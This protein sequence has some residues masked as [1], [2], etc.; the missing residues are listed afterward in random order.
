MGKD[1]GYPVRLNWTP[2][3]KNGPL[4]RCTTCKNVQFFRS[5]IVVETGVDADDTPQP[6][7]ASA[8]R[9]AQP[10][11]AIGLDEIYTDTRIGTCYWHELPVIS[12]PMTA[13][14]FESTIE[15]TF[16]GPPERRNYRQQ[17]IVL[18]SKRNASCK[19]ARLDRLM[20]TSRSSPY[21]V[22]SIRH[23]SLY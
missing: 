5:S 14:D 9:A 12:L 8:L 20:S 13:T 7:A 17:T 18:V 4:E 15:I 2:L 16:F 6:K 22:A 10:F 21:L 1:K 11:E 23:V 3:L 19:S